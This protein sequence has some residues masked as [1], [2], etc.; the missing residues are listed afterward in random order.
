LREAEEAWLTKL[1][2]ESREFWET[3]R[4]ESIAAGRAAT[5]E[6]LSKALS[7]AGSAHFLNGHAAE[8]S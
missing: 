1:D 4:A 8:V 5:V 6:Q 7:E 2:N 3:Q